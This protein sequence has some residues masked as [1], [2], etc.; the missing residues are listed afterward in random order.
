M[1]INA[2]YNN[3]EYRMVRKVYWMAK[4]IEALQQENKTLQNEKHNADTCFKIASQENKELRDEFQSMVKV[5]RNKAEQ[6]QQEIEQLKTERD[7]FKT[8]WEYKALENQ[9]LLNRLQISPFGDDKIDELEQAMEFIRFE[10][11][12]LKI[13]YA[14]L[15][16]F[17]QSQCAKLL[18]ENGR[19]KVALKRARVTLYTAL[20]HSVLPSNEAPDE[21]LLETWLEEAIAEI[22][23]ALGGRK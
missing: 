16:D 5:N 8:A 21:D 15:N 11:E 3:R 20:E 19:L 7:E 14:K 4:K 2:L 1:G 13:K 12:Q 18:A 10:N 6:L 22:E 17:E 9:R 23:K